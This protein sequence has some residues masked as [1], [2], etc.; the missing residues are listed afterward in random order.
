MLEEE[1]KEGL[2]E[3]VG[4]QEAAAARRNHLPDADRGLTARITNRI[5]RQKQTGEEEEVLTAVDVVVPAAQLRNEACACACWPHGCARV[6]HVHG[7]I[8]LGHAHQLTEQLIPEVGQRQ[9][10]KRTWLCGWLVVSYI[11]TD[12]RAQANR[13]CDWG[14][15]REREEK[16]YMPCE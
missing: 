4:R 10:L 14:K 3:L 7:G 13:M 2:L 16:W 11:Y 1:G 9:S 12:T 8:V 15:E 6:V 5:V